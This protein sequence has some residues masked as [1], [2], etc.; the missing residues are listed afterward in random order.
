MIE[1][2]KLTE[3]GKKFLNEQKIPIRISVLNESN[4]PSILSLWYYHKEDRFYCATIN[5]ALVVKYLEKNNKCA[6]EISTEK[7]PYKGIRGQGIATLNYD[8]GGDVLKVL[9]EKYEIKKNSQLE[10]FLL[11]RIEDEIAIE[12]KPTKLFSWDYSKRMQDA[13]K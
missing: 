6:F 1:K 3:L 9:L 2:G 5:T 12:I 4:W 8:K 10:K 13:V 7:P 11:S